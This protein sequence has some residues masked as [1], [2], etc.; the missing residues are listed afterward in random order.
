M[1]RIDDERRWFVFDQVL[2]LG[3]ELVER[4]ARGRGEFCE[5]MRILEVVP[6]NGRVAG[7]WPG[8]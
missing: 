3:L 5:L 2:E 8:R 6:A 1:L 4:Q 7:P